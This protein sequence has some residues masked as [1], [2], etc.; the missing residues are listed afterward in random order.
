MKAALEKNKQ[1]Y[2]WMVMPGE[3]HGFRKPE[4]LVKFYRAVE[5][6]LKENIGTKE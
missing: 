2:I 5:E 3:G 6:F 4:N 1:K